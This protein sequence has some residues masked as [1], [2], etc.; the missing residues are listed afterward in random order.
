MTTCS[1]TGCTK[2]LRSNNT[3][4]LCATNCLSPDAAPSHRA[5]AVD[6]AGGELGRTRAEKPAAETGNAMAKFRA[7]AE[8]V[9]LD[10]DQVLEEFAQSWLDG[11]RETLES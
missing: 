11:L 9:G 1:R 8:V 2:T 7:V 6:G 10:P 5:K 3:T 4:G